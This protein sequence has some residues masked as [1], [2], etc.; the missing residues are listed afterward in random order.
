M[1]SQPNLAYSARS[2]S[3]FCSN[4]GPV[5][6]ELVKNILSETLNLRLTFDGGADTPDDVVDCT[7][8][9]FAG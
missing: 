4:P 5:H 8:S 9:D 3:L 7:D 6:V 2:L 1:H